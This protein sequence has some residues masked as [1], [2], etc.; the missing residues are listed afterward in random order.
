MSKTIKAIRAEIFLGDISLNVYQMPNG[1]YKLAGR[2]V[3]DAVGEHNSSL[4]REMGVKSLKALP[5]AD[6]SLTHLKAESGETFIPVAIQDATEYWGRVAKKGNHLAIAILVASATEAIERRADAAFN[7]KR[8]EEERNERFKA[9]VEGKI[10]RRTFTDAIQAYIDRHPEL[11]GSRINFMYNNASDRV[12]KAVFGRV[13]KILC[14]DFKADKDCLRD[15]FNDT[16]LRRIA[17]V[18][19]EAMYLIDNQD[20]DPC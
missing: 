7:V 14:R 1:E 9:R 13:A 3:T 19:E 16:E 12:N 6:L 5:N 20:V 11:S 17:M 4:T 15:S 2:N 10:A 8:T 18:E